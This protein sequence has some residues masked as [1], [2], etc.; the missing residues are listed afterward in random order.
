MEDKAKEIS[1]LIWQWYKMAITID[2]GEREW[3]ALLEE[4]KKM[5]EKYKD[6]ELNYHLATDMFFAF[7]E[8]IERLEKLTQ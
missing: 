8:H 6:D 4:A 1:S 3:D 2:K 5:V 7:E